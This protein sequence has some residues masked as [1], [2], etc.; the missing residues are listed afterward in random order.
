MSEKK[1]LGQY[2]EGLSPKAR[3]M[4]VL[5]GVGAVLV[6]F[7]YMFVSAGPD[8]RESVDPRQAVVKDILTDANTRELGI[9]GL[10]NRTAVLEGSVEELSSRLAELTGELEIASREAVNADELAEQLGH[11][12]EALKEESDREASSDTENDP[13]PEQGPRHPGTR[14]PTPEA[15][16]PPPISPDIWKETAP[17]A[18]ASPEEGGEGKSSSAARHS[19]IDIRVIDDGKGGLAEADG[20]SDQGTYLPAGSIVSG[21]LVT[22][23]DAPTNNSSR[24]EPFPALVRV[25]KDAILPNRHLLDVRECFII[26]SGY[27]SLSAER[28]YLR[29]EVL[30]CVRNDGGV[31]EVPMNAYAVGEDGKVGL[32]GRV[33]SKQGQMLGKS[34]AAGFF[35]GMSEVFGRAPVPTIQTSSSGEIPYQDVLSSDSVTAGAVEGASSALDRLAEFYLDM[36]ENI[37]PVIEVNANRSVDFV[38]TQGGW[39]KTVAGSESA[40]S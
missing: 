28:A 39:L 27:G 4:V 20:E 33:V 31:I 24:S 21:V 40:S 17:V 3:R 1:L 35:S 18:M 13:S 7:A 26:G 23:M 14:N 34:L 30:S 8:D 15:P 6:L 11:L 29:A 12:R 36:A 9:D 16:E 10:D 19:S 25:Q 37:F 38:I 32:R 22:G 5:T 2:W